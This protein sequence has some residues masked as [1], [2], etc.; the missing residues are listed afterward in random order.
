MHLSTT[1][2]VTHDEKEELLF[3]ELKAV[4]EKQAGGAVSPDP[5][6]LDRICDPGTGSHSI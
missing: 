3:R 5:G 2:N 6:D 4:L 1:D